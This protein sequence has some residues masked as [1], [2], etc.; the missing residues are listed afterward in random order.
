MGGISGVNAAL[1]SIE[2]IMIPE[3]IIRLVPSALKLLG[4]WALVLCGVQIGWSQTGELHGQASAWIGAHLQP[5]TGSEAG[6]RYIPDFLLEQQL[7]DKLNLN[8]EL[9]LNAFGTAQYAKNESALYDLNV[10]PYRGWLRLSTDRFEARIGLQ[11][12][13]FGS[14]SMLRPLMWFDR[15]DPRD[16][17][18]LTDGVYAVLGRYYF[19]NN[20]NLWLWGLYGNND[21]KGWELAATENKTV[22]YGGRIQSPLWTG[23]VGLTYHHRRADL[24]TM[25]S[26]STGYAGLNVPEDR[27]GVDGKWDIG[28][29]V[30]FEG[31]LIHQQSEL[32]GMT[33]QRQWTIGTD[34]TFAVGNGVSAAMEYFQSEYPAGEFTSAA[35]HGLSALSLTYSMGV[36]DQ[37]SAMF[38]RDWHNKE[39]YRLISWHR[40]YDNWIFYFTGFWNPENVQLYRPQS[41]E[42]AFAGTGFQLMVVFNH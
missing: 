25:L 2:R 18:Q 42:N 10:K 31:A 26:A 12:I 6:L 33:Y 7:G 36:V 37:L 17:L 29:G 30:W 35:G 24:N 14:A 20:A 28:I 21:T 11:K 8:L 15:I 1:H 34:Y 5:S 9:S 19:Q 22:E 38:Y 27:Y 32:F 39:W 13:N 41:G 3:Q 4:C 23:E 16:P 40:T